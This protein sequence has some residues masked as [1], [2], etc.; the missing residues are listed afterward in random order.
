MGDDD[1]VSDG[2]LELVLTLTSPSAHSATIEN[3]T[4]TSG[5][6]NLLKKYWLAFTSLKM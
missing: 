6:L 5:G 2:F 3:F 1:F 4:I